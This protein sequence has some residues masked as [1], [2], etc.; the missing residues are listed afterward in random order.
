[1]HGLAYVAKEIMKLGMGILLNVR[2]TNRKHTKFSGGVLSQMGYSLLSNSYEKMM[3]LTKF[4][5]EVTN[6]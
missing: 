3:I 2:K 4:I 5:V 6:P 1:M